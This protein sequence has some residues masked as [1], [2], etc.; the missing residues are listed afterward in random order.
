MNLLFLHF[1]QNLHLIQAKQ[2]EN[3]K[4]IIYWSHHVSLSNHLSFHPTP[5]LYFKQ[6]TGNTWQK[7]LYHD[8]WMC[9]D[10]DPTLFDQG[11]VYIIITHGVYPGELVICLQSSCY[12]HDLQFI[13][14]IWMI[15]INYSR[16]SKSCNIVFSLSVLWNKHIKIIIRYPFFSLSRMRL[17][18]RVW[19]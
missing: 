17:G 15:N 16:V 8:L 1:L 3:K 11:Q 7:G 14:Q 18:A 9:H 2:Y 6:N 19:W 4:Y 5:L 13:L 12:S 10:L